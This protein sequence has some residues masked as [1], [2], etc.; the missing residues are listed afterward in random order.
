MIPG[1]ATLAAQIL[2]GA[3][4]HDTTPVV[5]SGADDRTDTTLGGLV[6]DAERVAGGR[7]H[8]GVGHGDVV[9]V[10]LPGTSEGA[11][12]QA[13][14]ALSGAVLLPIVSIYGPR[15]LEFI[16]RQSGAVVLVVPGSWRGRDQAAVVAGMRRPP[17]LRAVVVTGERVPEG[18]IAFDDLYGRLSRPYQRPAPAPDSR[19]MLVYTSG[20][21]A[22]PKGVQHSRRTLL[23]EVFSPVMARDAGRPVRHL[24]LFPPGHVA[25]LLGLI[26]VLVHGTSTVVMD[27]WDPARAAALVD[28]YG[29]TFGVGAPVQLAGLLDERDRGAAAL[30]TLVELMTG[31]A[32]VPPSLIERAD[33]AG[34]AAYR[35][36]GSSEHPTIS[37]GAVEDALPKQSATDGRIIAGTEVRIVSDDGRD[38]PGGQDGE[39]LSRGP[40]LFLGY[41]DA[42]LNRAA[43]LSGGW[44]RTG[45]VGRIDSD[46]HLTITDRKKDIIIRG[47]EN[48]S[49]KEAE[50]LLAGHPA[51]AEVAVIGVPDGRLGER[52]CAA[53]VPR[54]GK[55]IHLDQVREYFDASGAARQ[56]TPEHVAV[57]TELPRTSAGKVQKHILRERLGFGGDAAS[58]L[59]S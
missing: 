41:T 57:V 7:A 10:Q 34:V 56:K 24:A 1:E 23:P 46:G 58:G 52:V 5:F 32:A 16:L 17:T 50:D 30:S 2:R 47:G 45:D 54:P 26:R 4:D 13:A 3:A 40:E 37:S 11:V 29:I 21:T 55:T 20:T 22:E 51:V 28:E 36:Y 14:V 18:M 49:A 43:F 33:E 6:T 12:A 9:A 8:L 42:E 19:A 35:T 59:S 48:I 39:I 27:S 31:A 38:V 53:V 44:F 25:G 15:E